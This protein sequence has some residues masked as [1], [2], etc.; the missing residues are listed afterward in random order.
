M[1]SSL[2]LH[3]LLPSSVPCNIRRPH[4]IGRAIPRYRGV[5]GRNMRR[6][7]SPNV[8]HRRPEADQMPNERL[9][10]TLAESEYDERSMADELGLDQKSVQRWITRNVTPRRTTAHRAAKLLGVPAPWLGH[11]LETDR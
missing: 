4:G 9:R 1:I 5:A 6:P 10:A 11:D 2:E 8:P 3:R 7:T